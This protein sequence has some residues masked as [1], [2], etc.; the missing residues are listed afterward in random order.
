MQKPKLRII[1]QLL[2]PFISILLLQLFSITPF[3]GFSQ[4]AGFEDA[5]RKYVET[6]RDIAIKEM[7]DYGIP[8]SITLA[9][10]ILESDAGRS[11]LAREANNHFGIKCHVEWHGKTFYKDDETNNECFRMYD[12]PEES[13]RD[14]SLFLSQRDRYKDLFKLDIND[15][16]AWANGL[17]AAG[18]ATNP[19]YPDHLIKTIEQ[20]DLDRYDR[21]GAIVYNKN[22]ISKNKSAKVVGYELY[23]DGPGNRPVYI[24]NGL[25]FI[26]T[27]DGDN[28]VKIS[29][30]FNVS[31][32][33]IDQW[34]DLSQAGNLTPGQLIYLEPKKRKC[35]DMATHAVSQGETMHDIAQKYGVKLKILYH[36][37]HMIPRQRPAEKQIILLR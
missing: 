37:N 6:Y 33:R 16:A 24:N 13:F 30:D 11:K 17:K 20:F 29:N 19:K 18:Y 34:N 27:R 26:I 23:A 9:Q 22:L 28:L 14:H 35:A 36:R 31:I 1:H 21:E 25:Q 15:Y 2:F 12:H 3:S 7:K 5:V 4:A 8:A 32:K 10:G